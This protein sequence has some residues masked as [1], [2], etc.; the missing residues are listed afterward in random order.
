M[1]GVNR[2]RLYLCGMQK[3][4]IIAILALYLI[5]AMGVHVQIHFCCGQLAA[6]EWNPNVDADCKNSEK[7][8]KKADCCSSILIQADID[9]EHMASAKLWCY[10][11]VVL[12]SVNHHEFSW[13][14]SL[15]SDQVLA[16]DVYRGPPPI[17]GKGRCCLFH[18]WKMD[19]VLG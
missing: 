6:L 9:D 17:A 12:A 5:G 19:P 1:N 4:K 18:N 10:P 7:C 15:T 2:F 8:C 14:V 11:N 3:W 16:E 13:S